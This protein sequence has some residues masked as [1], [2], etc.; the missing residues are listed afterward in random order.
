MQVPDHKVAEIIDGELIVSPRPAS[1]H[2][3][4]A[5]VIGADLVGPFHR[6]PGTPAGPG[7]WWILPEPELHLET[8]VLVPD[9]AGWRRQ[10]LPILRNV[11][12]FTLVPDWACEIL[13]PGTA[14]ID[15][16][17]KM[18]IYARE[19]VSH[20]WFVDPLLRTLEI[21]RLENGQWM[22]LA[23]HGADDLVRAEP[24]DAVEVA[25]ARWWL[26]DAEPAGA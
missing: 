3:H 7:G 1:P 19:G 18:G 12:F 24:F 26:P 20:L 17:R 2:A 25:L 15:R 9:W 6:E 5:A 10:R 21:N 11:P 13:S 8:D 14:R 23:N 16:G 4:A 22:V